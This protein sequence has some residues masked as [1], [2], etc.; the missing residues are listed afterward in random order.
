MQPRRSWPQCLL[1][2]YQT[3]RSVFLCGKVAGGITRHS[4]VRNPALFSSEMLKYSCDFSCLG[5]QAAGREEDGLVMW[6]YH[7]ILVV[8]DDTKALVYDLDTRLTFPASFET[9]CEATFGDEN[10]IPEKFRRKLRVIPGGD[11]LTG[12]SSDRRH[13]RGEEGE[14]LKPPPLWP[15]I[16][17]ISDVKHN[18]ES[19]I[20]MEED[21]GLGVVCD[22]EKF[23]RM[24][25]T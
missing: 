14:W 2:S 18:L 13:M 6:D 10:G 24:F 19:F 9:Y 8:R 12:L 25:S 3:R 11:Y 1:S 5:S 7:V 17:G 21:R 16:Q 15:C 22:L 20:S 4:R 23:M